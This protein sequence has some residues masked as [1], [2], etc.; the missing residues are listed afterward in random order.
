MLPCPVIYKDNSESKSRKQTASR[1]AFF[2]REYTALLHL[3]FTLPALAD[4]HNPSQSS[5]F[6]AILIDRGY[7]L[8]INLTPAKSTYFSF[9][10]VA[11]FAFCRSTFLRENLAAL[12]GSPAVQRPTA[13]L[14]TVNPQS[15]LVANSCLGGL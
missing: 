1:L 4:T 7:Q 15:K 13:R 14:L 9:L 8:E 5:H 6:S 11:E 2:A 10:I 12:P 3:A